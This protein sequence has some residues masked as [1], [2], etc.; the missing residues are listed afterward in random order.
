[1]TF[2]LT[3]NRYKI[4]GVIISTIKADR[5]ERKLL[6]IYFRH[7]TSHRQNGAETIHLFVNQTHHSNKTDQSFVGLEITACQFGSGPKWSNTLVELCWFYV[8]QHYAEFGRHFSAIWGVSA[9]CGGV[10]QPFW[11]DWLVGGD[12]RGRDTKSAECTS[13]IFIAIYFYVLCY[14]DRSQLILMQYMFICILC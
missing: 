8:G 3:A 2:S 1:M 6:P 12:L 13:L 7:W 4:N 14:T 10:L 11:L 5:V 9:G